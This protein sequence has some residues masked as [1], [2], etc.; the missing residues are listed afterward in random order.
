MK[1]NLIIIYIQSRYDSIQSD[2]NITI[3]Q[4]FN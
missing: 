2:N 3:E 4:P 1:G